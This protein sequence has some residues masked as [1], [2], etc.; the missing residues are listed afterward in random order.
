MDG[1][2]QVSDHQRDG[3]C[4]LET[5]APPC[6]R[7]RCR[8][9]PAA[10]QTTSPRRSSAEVRVDGRGHRA[11]GRHVGVG[12][13]AR[14]GTSQCRGDELDQHSSTAARTQPHATRT[15]DGG[16]RR[17]RIPLPHQRRQHAARPT[18][19][20]PARIGLLGR[21]PR[22]P[23][24]LPLAVDRRAVRLGADLRP[25]HAGRLP[26]SRTS[27][28]GATWSRVLADGYKIDGAHFCVDTGPAEWPAAPALRCP[29]GRDSA[30]PPAGLDAARTG[31][32][33][34]RGD[35]R[36]HRHGDEAPTGRLR[37]ATSTTPWARSAPTSTATRCARRTWARTPTPT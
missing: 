23:G 25:G 35:E 27:P 14:S 13:A 30:Q 1:H 18:G 16:R 21:G 34:Q 12:A 19:A 20:G 15:G 4:G 5:R 17:S 6:R 9:R 22:L 8:R 11:D 3:D 26:A 10:G 7:G 28:T 37:R 32:R 2:D 24:H 33:G 36:R 29:R 31:V